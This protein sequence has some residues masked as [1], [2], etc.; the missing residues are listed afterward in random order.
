MGRI[1][2]CQ[3]IG[4]PM[5][6]DPSPLIENLFLYYYE[7]VW[8]LQIKKL[9]L[10][11]PRMFSNIFRFIDEL[12]TLNND[13]FE[14]NYN[15]ICPDDLELKAE[16]EEPC[17]ALFLDLSV[18]VHNRKFIFNLDSNTSS[19]TFYVSIGSEI[20]CIAGTITEL[21]NKLACIHL[22]LIRMNKYHLIVDTDHWKT[23][24][25]IS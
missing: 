5:G 25:S 1:S 12:C 2:F 15:D 10:R 20:L 4:I 7:R 8:L 24:L 19:K 13:E 14:N 17:K 21:I 3:L 11:K 23:L 9:Y 16:N 18:E 22:L 6:S